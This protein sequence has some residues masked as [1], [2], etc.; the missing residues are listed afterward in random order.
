MIANEAIYFFSI[1][2]KKVL[3]IDSTKKRL[4]YGLQLKIFIKMTTIDLGVLYHTLC[5]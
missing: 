3:F 2:I 4:I 5:M 1:S